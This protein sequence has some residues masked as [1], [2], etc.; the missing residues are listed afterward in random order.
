MIE[1]PVCSASQNNTLYSLKATPFKPMQCESCQGKLYQTG[2]W[3]D[4]AKVIL[5]IVAA[6]AAYILSFRMPH[7]M[8]SVVLFAALVLLIRFAFKKSGYKTKLTRLN[9]ASRI[10][11]WLFFM[12]FFTTISSLYFMLLSHSLS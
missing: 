12:V 6:C 5:D 4:I 2:F 7:R 11:A 1:C 8:L 3:L 10:A 9:I